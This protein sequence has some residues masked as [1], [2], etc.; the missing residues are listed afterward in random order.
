M[1]LKLRWSKF[2]ENVL[3]NEGEYIPPQKKKNQENAKEDSSIGNEERS[4]VG[5]TENGEQ[6]ARG[7][8]FLALD[9]PRGRESTLQSKDTGWQN[10]FD[11]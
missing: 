7:Q 2:K 5:D 8:S 4:P 10:G 1:L 11:F 6:D 3:R 9:C